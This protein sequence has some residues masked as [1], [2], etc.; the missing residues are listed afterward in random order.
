MQNLLPHD[1]RRLAFEARRLTVEILVKI[2]LEQ[3]AA[4]RHLATVYLRLMFT[5]SL[6]ALAG[7]ITLY[8]A[9]LRL[10]SSEVSNLVT[11]QVAVVSIAA[12]SA[13]IASA[14]LSARALQQSAFDAAPLLHNPFPSAVTAID[15]IFNHEGLNER[16]ILGKLYFTISKTIED[17]PA[18]RVKARVTT[19]LLIA[20]LLLTGVSFLM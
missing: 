12:L 11:L 3:V 16:K 17:Q 6:G 8:G 15:E 18:L 10:S 1:E 5:L 20:G 13:L 2:Y 19:I 4:S 14:L 7:V 9:I